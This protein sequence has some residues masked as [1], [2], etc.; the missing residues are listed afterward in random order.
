MKDWIQRFIDYEIGIDTSSAEIDQ[1]EWMIHELNQNDMFFASKQWGEMPI[2]PIVFRGPLS[3]FM[4]SVVYPSDFSALEIVPL[5]Q[6][7]DGWQES[8][9]T[10]CLESLV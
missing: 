8:I 9:D 5:R 1:I 4:C 2:R 7:I 3:G 10:S 6:I